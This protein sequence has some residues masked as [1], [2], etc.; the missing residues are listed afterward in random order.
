MKNLEL[1]RAVLK[2]IDA[3]P[4]LLDMRVWA[5]RDAPSTVAC[6]VGRTLL[7]AG[8]FPDASGRFRTPDG[9]P[10]RTY[11]ATEAAS[12]LGLTDEERYGSGLGGPALFH[13]TAAHAAARFRK[14]VETAEA[15]GTAKAACP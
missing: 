15:E 1:R 8:Y 12:L 3:D 7:E 11:P 10:L 14:I 4:G 5:R 2:Q 6:L 13:D 9:R